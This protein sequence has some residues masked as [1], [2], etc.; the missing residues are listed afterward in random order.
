M[1]TR[2]QKWGNSLAVRI[3]KSCLDE[4]KLKKNSLIDVTVQDGKIVILPVKKKRK[5]TLDE[6]LTKI[7]PENRHEAVEWG[8]PVGKEVW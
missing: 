7:T 5:R 4:S 3:P 1:Q 6:L 2:V 8:P